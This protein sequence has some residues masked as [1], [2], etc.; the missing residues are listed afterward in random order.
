MWDFVKQLCWVK[1]FASHNFATSSQLC[2]QRQKFPPA[3]IVHLKVRP[4]RGLKQNIR[5]QPSQADSF[6]VDCNLVITSIVPH[7]QNLF[8][9][10]QRLAEIL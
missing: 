9:V 7:G 10:Y 8:Q 2:A 5:E 3:S 4:M 6:A 1:N